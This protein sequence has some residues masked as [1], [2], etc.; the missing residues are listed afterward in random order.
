[1]QSVTTAYLPSGTGFKYTPGAIT[2]TTIAI[3]DEQAWST[4]KKAVRVYDIAVNGNKLGETLILKTGPSTNSSSYLTVI[5]ETTTG[6]ASGYSDRIFS[7]GLI[8]PNG[9]YVSSGTGFVSA[10]ISYIVEV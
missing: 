6:L 1:M 4:G 5:V 7:E 2:A 3:V 8:F 9:L 10:L